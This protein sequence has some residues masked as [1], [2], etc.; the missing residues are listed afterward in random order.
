[1]Q[2]CKSCH[3]ESGCKI[4]S[5][6]EE[7]RMTCD[8]CGKTRSCYNCYSHTQRFRRRV[9]KEVKSREMKRETRKPRRSRPE[10]FL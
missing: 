8:K 10:A 4:G 2:L 3:N 9:L 7:C 6:P 5:H 1:M